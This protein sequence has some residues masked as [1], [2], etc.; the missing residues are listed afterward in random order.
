MLTAE[1]VRRLVL[2]PVAVGV[3]HGSSREGS[4]ASSH[5]V[6]FAFGRQ[7]AAEVLASLGFETEAI[8]V[9]PRGAP[10]WPEGVVGSISHTD[11]LAISVAARATER[12]AIGIDVER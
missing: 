6:E 2:P 7:A 4:P 9:G 10:R 8:P 11:G 5:E 1:D 12:T 3:R